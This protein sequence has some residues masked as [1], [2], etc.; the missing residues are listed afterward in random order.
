MNLKLLK[1]KDFAL[2]IFGNTTSAVGSNMQQF[3]LALYILAISNS[4]TLFAAITAIAIL[5][6]LILSPVAGVFGD[7]FDRKISI[8]VLDAVNGIMISGFAF[9]FIVNGGLS[10]PAIFLL[11]I[12]LEITEI[13]YGASMAAVMP[14]IVKT[15]QLF[16][17]SSIRSIVNNLGN[18]LAPLFASILYA[19]FGLLP[20]LIANAASF[21]I[22]SASHGFMHIPKSNVMPAKI[23]IKNFL[24]DLKEGFLIIK[25]NKA[26]S[27]FINLGV[28]INFCMA[29]LFSVVM[30]I[31][32]RESLGATDIQYG[33]MSTILSVSMLAGPLLLGKKAAKMSV[34]KLTIQSFIITSICTLIMF[35][36]SLPGITSQF[37][38]NVIPLTAIVIVTFIIG[39]VVSITNI[40]IGTLFNI[41]V[42]KEFMGRTGT[43]MNMGLTIAIPVGQ[44]L[45][46]FAMDLMHP[47]YVIGIIGT[48]ALCAILYYA[49]PLTK[50]LQ[51]H[52]STPKEA[53]CH[54]S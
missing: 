54:I 36:I 51:I 5:P 15:E 50:A 29:P 1:E 38:T 43:L 4:A 34:A 7:W 14:S 19:S 18:M 52:E 13:F 11:V 3:A 41:I 24:I 33:I 39:M 37:S 46:G 40:A 23:D 17:A 44:M 35:G 30:I 53:A 2:F 25:N 47:S 49:S 31:L 28:I 21:L 27:I 12:L 10:I 45:C 48:I 6:R 9:Y 32:I 26:I 22:A 20:I 16:E 8:M 42:P